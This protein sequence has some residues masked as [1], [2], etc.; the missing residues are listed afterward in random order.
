MMICLADPRS[1]AVHRLRTTTRRIEGQLALLA[2]IPDI[3]THDSL[4]KKIRRDLKKVRRA[5]G[6]VRDLDVQVDLID[7]VQSASRSQSLTHDSSCLRA[8]VET[9]RENNADRLQKLL[10]RYGV[11]L[12]GK[13]EELLDTLQ[14]VEST[15]LTS[16]EIAALARDWFKKSTPAEPAGHDDD[17]DYLHAMR[18]TAKLARYISENAPKTAVD[19]RKLARSFEEL[20]QAGGEWHDWLVLSALAANQ[21]GSDS[22]L[23]QNLTRRCRRSLQ[24]YK[25]RLSSEVV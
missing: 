11:E 4:A 12:A 18:K 15:T 10:R 20:Q 25:K 6:S 7:S 21:L 19:T 17:S 22:P 9:E 14:P 8:V 13:M 16:A 1:R 2:M 24:A 23:T 3:L 5:A